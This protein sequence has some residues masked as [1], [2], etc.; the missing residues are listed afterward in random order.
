MLS[1]LPMCDDRSWVGFKI[2]KRLAILAI[3][4][5]FLDLLLDNKSVTSCKNTITKESLIR[6]F[7]NILMVVLTTDYK[8]DQIHIPEILKR[9]K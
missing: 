6:T 7:I 8:K 3:P 9:L 4:Y 1:A 5:N 2:E